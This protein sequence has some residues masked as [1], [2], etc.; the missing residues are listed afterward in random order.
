MT[1]R[2]FHPDRRRGEPRQSGG[3]LF[4]ARRGRRHQFA[5]LQPVGGYQGVSFA[6]PIDLASKIKDQIVCA[7]QGGARQAGCLRQE[8]NQRWR[9][10]SELE[11][12]EGALVRMW[13]RAAPPTARPAVGRRDRAANGKTIVASGD[14]PASWACRSRARSWLLDVWRQASPLK[15]TPNLPQQRQGGG[16]RAGAMAASAASAGTASPG[17]RSAGNR[18]CAAVCWSRMSVAR[19]KRRA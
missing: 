12:P 16:G 7:R 19:P 14:L 18:A 13:R 8:V 17:C 9:T 6:I 11:R 5:D 2:A 1:A 10:P 3:P 15:L 4:N